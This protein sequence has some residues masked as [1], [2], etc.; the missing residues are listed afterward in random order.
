MTSIRKIFFSLYAVI[1]LVSPVLAADSEPPF[2]LP[3]KEEI[4]RLRSAIIY[5]N[6]G[7]LIVHLYPDQAP[8]HVANFKY[9][10]DKDFYKGLKFHIYEPNYVIQTGAPGR[11][12]NSGPGYELPPEFSDL[13]HEPGIL[14]MVRKPSDLDLQHTRRSHGS[15]FRILLRKAKTMDGRHTIFGKVVEGLDVLKRL[16][17]NDIVKDVVVFVKKK[18]EKVEAQE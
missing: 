1:A 14:S 5:T 3:S 4:V 2:K 13:K 6:K 10:A 15:Q 18:D 17:K 11:R 7:K 9:L 16:R 8:W 12:V